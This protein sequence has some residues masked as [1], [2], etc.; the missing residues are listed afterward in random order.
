[1]MKIQ[2]ENI[3]G[4]FQWIYGDLTVMHVDLTINMDVSNEECRHSLVV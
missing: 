4:F 3:D 1:M 2:P